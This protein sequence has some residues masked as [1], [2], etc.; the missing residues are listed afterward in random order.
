MEEARSK[1]FKAVVKHI[2]DPCMLICEDLEKIF[3]AANL[4]SDEPLTMRKILIQAVM[5]GYINGACDAYR[6]EPYIKSHNESY[7]KFVAQLRYL[8]DPV[9]R[10]YI[11]RLNRRTSEASK[12]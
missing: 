1:E 2:A 12:E 5:S 8:I 9:R 4:V 11:E 3:T 6:I 10:Q 7:E